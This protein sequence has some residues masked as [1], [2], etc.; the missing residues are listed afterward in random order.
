MSVLF[1]VVP[2]VPGVPALSRLATSVVA[3]VVTLTADAA[4]IRR[5]FQGPQWGVF[6]NGAPYFPDAVVL[7]VE[8][9]EGYRVASHPVENGGF[10]A[11]NKVKE[12]WDA[13]LILAFDGTDNSLLGNTLGNADLFT[14]GLAGGQTTGQSNR[15]LAIARL[16]A[17]VAS[18]DMF[19][20][21]TPEFTWPSANVVRYEVNRRGG[22]ASLLVVDVMVEEVRVAAPP[23]FTDTQNP[24]GADAVNGG[25]P[26]TTD[27]TP[28]QV[29]PA[30]TG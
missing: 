9:R 8:L 22:N 27:P 23:D 18:L 24:E 7:G 4:S 20:V 11:Y 26:Q 16:R 17:A 2:D 28:Q 6:L 21:V 25:T 19:S 10:A 13:R 1:P 12:P 3:P 15:A 14:A 5:A 29:P 30:I